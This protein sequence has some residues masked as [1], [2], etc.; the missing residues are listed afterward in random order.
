MVAVVLLAMLGVTVTEFVVAAL[1]A[2]AT[3]V[4]LMLVLLVVISTVGAVLVRREGGRAWSAFR[5]AL[6]AQQP[7]AREVANGALIV[8]AGALL[9]T[10]G[11]VTDAVGLLLLLPPIR[12]LARRALLGWLA[13]R[14][15]HSRLRGTTT[16]RRSSP[17]RPTVIDSEA[18]PPRDER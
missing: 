11:F 8:V 1:V 2:R 3:S 16:R 10:P 4:P 7:P 13:Q 17:G 18:L 6:S 15:L 5:T 12:V 9:L 14:L